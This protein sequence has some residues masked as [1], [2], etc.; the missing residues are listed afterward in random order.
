MSSV[1]EQI[2]SK[3]YGSDLDGIFVWDVRYK[4]EV[5]SSFVRKHCR[6][7]VSLLDIGCGFGTLLDLLKNDFSSRCGCDLFIPDNDTHSFFK[8]D[9]NNF[10]DGDFPRAGVV[11]CSHVLQYLNNPELVFSELASISDKYFVVVVPLGRCAPKSGMVHVFS[12]KL[13]NDWAHSNMCVVSKV[14]YFGGFYHWLAKS[15]LAAH[16]YLNGR[17]Y[18]RREYADT[19]FRKSLMLLFLKLRFIDYFL[20]FFERKSAIFLVKKNE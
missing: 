12:E 1:T 18:V 7:R 14:F 20:S 2:F 9:L 16:S 15:V 11:V 3:E 19:P 10:A 13:I 6:S 4:A 5:I 8:V 17:S